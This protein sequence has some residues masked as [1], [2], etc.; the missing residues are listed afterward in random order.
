MCRCGSE[1]QLEVRRKKFDLSL[2][3]VHRLILFPLVSAGGMSCINL[4]SCFSGARSAPDEWT[5]G[6]RITKFREVYGWTR[7][8]GSTLSPRVMALEDS[9]CP[10][11]SEIS[12]SGMP[13]RL[14]R[15]NDAL[16]PR[17]S[18]T[19]LGSERAN[20]EDRV[21]KDS[22][23]SFYALF[24]YY[25]CALSDDTVIFSYFSACYYSS[26]GNGLNCTK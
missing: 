11:S 18:T 9:P 4:R 21:M 19:R 14:S 23:Y 20:V 25:L 2:V 10:V 8:K 1:G 17:L 13:D 22:I 26:E 7:T 24:L 12:S 3:R 6:C 16:R 15:K 5:Q